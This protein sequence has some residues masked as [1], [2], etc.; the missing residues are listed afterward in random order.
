MWRIKSFHDFSLR[1]TGVPFFDSNDVLDQTNLSVS[2]LFSMDA[3]QSWKWSENSA[4]FVS[5]RAYVCSFFRSGS[6]PFGVLGTGVVLFGFVPFS[7]E[8]LKVK[9]QVAVQTVFTVLRFLPLSLPFCFH[10]S[11]SYVLVRVAVRA[12]A[13]RKITSQRCNRNRSDDS[14]LISAG[15][16]SSTGTMTLW[17]R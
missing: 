8:S 17:R 11:L 10:F 12:D 4:E 7:P 3:Q 16:P 9:V 15:L 6:R 14:L 5:S 2:F 1:I 13:K